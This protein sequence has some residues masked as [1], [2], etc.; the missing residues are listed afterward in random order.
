MTPRD[1]SSTETPGHVH[2]WVDTV[3]CGPVCETCGAMPV[4]SEYTALEQQLAQV[5]A[6]RDAAREMQA[7]YRGVGVCWMDMTEKHRLAIRKLGGLLTE[8]RRQ[9]RMREGVIMQW[10]EVITERIAERDQAI[11]R[12]EAAAL[13]AENGR[14]ALYGMTKRYDEERQRAEAS[15]AAVEVLVEALQEVKRQLG[16]GPCGRIQDACSGCAEGVDA[17]VT[18]VGVTL[19]NLPATTQALLARRKAEQAFIAAYGEMVEIGSEAGT[20]P[21]PGST[22]L[23]VYQTRQKAVRD[24]WAAL[25]AVQP[26][27]GEGG[28]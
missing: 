26:D 7:A 23:V 3:A 24:A 28:V 13:D 2:Q 25:R 11:Q 22:W 20:W 6:E 5:A 17:A 19:D 1:P 4:A 10:R 12:A 18:A 15:E 8:T 9:L 27:A 14:N 21:T 16:D